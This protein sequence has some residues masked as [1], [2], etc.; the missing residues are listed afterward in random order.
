MLRKSWLNRHA[1][2]HY[3]VVILCA[4]KWFPIPLEIGMAF[5]IIPRHGSYKVAPQININKYII[6]L[7]MQWLYLFLCKKKHPATFV[8]VEC[9]SICNGFLKVLDNGLVIEFVKTLW[10]CIVSN[11]KPASFYY[12]STQEINVVD[13]QIVGCW[14]I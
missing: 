7:Q 4:I 12:F 1:V 14:T 5:L 11:W 8:V 3:R 10:Q 6:S 13:Y 2:E 9:P